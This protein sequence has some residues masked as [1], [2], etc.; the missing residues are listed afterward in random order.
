MRVICIGCDTGAMAR[1]QLLGFCQARY[2]L[3]VTFG[4]FATWLPSL[5]NSFGWT[6]R[7]DDSVNSTITYLV[8]RMERSHWCSQNVTLGL[9]LERQTMVDATTLYCRAASNLPTVRVVHVTEIGARLVF[10]LLVGLRV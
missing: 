10:A 2:D 3:S 7:D 9:R 8:R 4:A 6:G 5:D 1:T